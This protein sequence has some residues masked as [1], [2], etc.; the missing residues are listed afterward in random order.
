MRALHA[1]QL[2]LYGFAAGMVFVA[3]FDGIENGGLKAGTVHLHGGP[4]WA[5]QKPELYVEDDSHQVYFLVRVAS[6]VN[7]NLYQAWRM[8]DETNG[9]SGLKDRGLNH[10]IFPRQ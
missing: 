8:M 6:D 5:A 7:D 3:V 9:L 10:R 4:S 2:F 1:I